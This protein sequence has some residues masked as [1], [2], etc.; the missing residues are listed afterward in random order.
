MFSNQTMRLVD[1][2]DSSQPL[3]IKNGSK[4]DIYFIA[5]NKYMETLIATIGV[6][7]TPNITQMLVGDTVFGLPYLV[8]ILVIMMI[9]LVTNMV[10]AYRHCDS[11]EHSYG[12]VYGAKK[13]L[14]TGIISNL[15]LLLL[16]AV[17]KL[18]YPLTVLSYVPILSNMVDGVVLA[19]TY[20]V[21]YFVVAWP[22]W[23]S[24]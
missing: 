23:G 8:N 20:F 6:L 2:N 21:S 18:R 22:I 17:P 19:L 14:T 24:C 15:V 13:G 3:C 7:L 16:D 9:T 4:R 5:D 11:E 12:I 10:R 1:V